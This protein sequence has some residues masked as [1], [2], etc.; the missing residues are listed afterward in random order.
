MF[1]RVQLNVGV[2]RRPMKLPRRQSLHV[3]YLIDCGYLKHRIIRKRH[4]V[5]GIVDQ[6]PEAGRTNA[7]DFTVRNVDPKLL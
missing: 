7:S 5:F 1:Q 4:E 2:K 3:E 6:Q